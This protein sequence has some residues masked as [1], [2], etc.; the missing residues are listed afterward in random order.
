MVEETSL[1]TGGKP[2]KG[3]AAR[4]KRRRKKDGESAGKRGR[5]PGTSFPPLPIE[6]AL[7]LANAIQ[8]H[9][10][11]QPIRRLTLFEKLNRSPESSSSRMIITNSNRYNLTE[12]GYHAE[13][14]N[15]TDL[16]KGATDPEASDIDKR[17]SLF[18]LSIASV[19]TFNLLYEK[20]KG[21]R[22]PSPEVMR[23]MLG[24]IKI[25]ED[26]RKM[27]VE[28]FLE[29]AR[30][31]GLLR[32]IAGAERLLPIDQ[33]LEELGG[34]VQKRGGTERKGEEPPI[35]SPRDLKKKDWK[36]VCFFIA[37]IGQPGEEE[38]KHSDMMLENLITRALEGEGFDV[39]RADR[40]SDP[41]MISAQVIDYI[42]R[43]ALVIA[44]LSFHNPNVFY[45]LAIRHMLGRPTVHIIRKRDAI[46]FDLKD[47]RTIQVDTEDK[48]ELVAKLETYRAEIA[49][50]VRLALESG[51][52]HSNP[53]RSSIPG[54][55]VKFN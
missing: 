6:A 51:D 49:T 50:Q 14:L 8:E 32:T 38:R 26:Q 13:I 43:S 34:T 39:V 52:T 17:K 55:D 31:L 18:S 5:P 41:G 45:E 16:G 54:L 30:Y 35:G 4:K 7:E 1:G 9:A 28:V 33:I 29:N 12:G 42:M 44:D 20:C 10:S 27:C 19:P 2:R 36:K 24:E 46:P 3:T 21:N 48:Y 47:F 53:I 11:G 40:I 15:L 37:P 25:P 22:L 23:D